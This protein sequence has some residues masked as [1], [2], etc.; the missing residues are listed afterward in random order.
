MRDWDGLKVVLNVHRAGGLAGAARA[1]R[2]SEP[3]VSR[4]LA[5]AEAEFDARLFDRSSGRLVATEAGLL[6]V[7]DA[8]AIERRLH[9]M[10]DAVR[11][12]DRV[13]AGKLSVSLPHQL[14][15]HAFADDLREFQQ[16]YPEIELIVQVSDAVV[17]F[18][19]SGIDVAIRAEPEQ[20][21]TLWGRRLADIHMGFFARTGSP[22]LNAG[23]DQD[24]TPL[25]LLDAP[26]REMETELLKRFP[27]GVV[28]A[29]CDSVEACVSMVRAGAGI[30]CLP[31][32]IGRANADLAPV[33]GAM[34]HARRALWALSHTDFRSVMRVE[35]FISFIAE[36][37]RVLPAGFWSPARCR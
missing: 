21:D 23:G 27:T 2:V 13:M 3:T 18:D 34:P 32:F 16:L 28:V 12:I 35:R 20:T 10:Q 31:W 11:S 37:A 36:R 8:E 6:V 26:G 19:S 1:L 5:R 14:L 25:V 7:R 33:P 4:Q 30:G 24:E 22:W 9:R 17:E 15:P 29:R